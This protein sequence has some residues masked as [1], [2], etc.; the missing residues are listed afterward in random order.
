MKKFSFLAM[1][2]VAVAF[3]LSSCQSEV[4]MFETNGTG[5]IALK[6][7]TAENVA[8]S[9]ATVASDDTDWK[10]VVNSDA[11]ITVKEL[12]S[13]AYAA[14]EDNSLSV[15]NYA[16]LNDALAANDNWG[17]AYWTGQTSSTFNIVA[18]KAA[19]VSVDCGKSKTSSLKVVFN[20]TF[21]QVANS[22]FSL[23]ATKDN[24]TLTYNASTG[25]K[26]GF[27]AYGDITYSINATVNGKSVNVSNKTLTLAEGTANTLTVKA[28]TNGTISLTINYT[29]L[30]TG[31]SD[32]VTIDAASGEEAH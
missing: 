32:E 20:E 24:R 1:A 16:S 3:G 19:S 23:T 5:S 10:V 14:K 13:K 15:Y 25:E 7:N 12:S 27:F 4:D 2:A 31:V 26:A 11:P 22:G 17:A 6:V 28:N 8:V 9:R 30:E 18:G 21:T 29:D